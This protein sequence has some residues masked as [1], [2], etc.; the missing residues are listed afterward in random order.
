VPK[1]YRSKWQ[2]TRIERIKAIKEESLFLSKVRASELPGL[3][4][5][6]PFMLEEVFSNSSPHHTRL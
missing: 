2:R 3:R 1:A 6:T 5:F 4:A